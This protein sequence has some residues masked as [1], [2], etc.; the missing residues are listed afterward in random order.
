MKQILGTLLLLLSFYSSYS[1]HRVCVDVINNQS[2][3]FYILYSDS[4][5]EATTKATFDV[6]NAV[7]SK[8]E[9]ENKKPNNN[10]TYYR[11]TSNQSSTNNNSQKTSTYSNKKT[12]SSSYKP[13]S[14]ICGARTKKG[15]PCQRRVVG[16]GYCYQ[17]R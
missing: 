4:T 12:S 9:I 6:Y 7:K 15:T 11:S 5:W 16:G 14:S 10:A 3:K 2:G 1:Q 13:T 17:H 8:S